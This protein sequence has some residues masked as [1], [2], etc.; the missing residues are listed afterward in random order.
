M[1]VEY[2]DLKC[3]SCGKDFQ[4]TAREYRRCVK[5]NKPIR[6]C[7][8]E[9]ATKARDTRVEKE[10][11]VCGKKFLIQ[12]R[13]SNQNKT[14]SSECAK[15]RYE[16]N[17]ELVPINCKNC[18]KIFYITKSY[19]KKQLK[20]GQNI[21]FCSKNCYNSFLRKNMIECVCI[22]CGKH[23]FLNKKNVSLK[24]NVCSAECRREINQKKPS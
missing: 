4:R 5:I 19:Y 14:C 23:F 7:S 2:I 18:N 1:S 13:L 9:C 12:A 11:P 22:N 16:Q 8:R 6:F 20:R 24:G 3:E 10:C 21:E 17:N 15:K